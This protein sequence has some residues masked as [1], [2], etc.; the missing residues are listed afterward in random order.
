MEDKYL[1]DVLDYLEYLNYPD[2]VTEFEP[3]CV[4]KSIREAALAC[5]ILELSIRS[6]ALIIFGLTFE[7]QIYR[8]GKVVH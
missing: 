7:Q 4:A 3:S 6:C 1:E 2:Y 8:D 5:F